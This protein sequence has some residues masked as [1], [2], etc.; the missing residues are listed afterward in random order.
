MKIKYLKSGLILSIFWIHFTLPALEEGIEELTK[1]LEQLQHK[2]TARPTSPD[3]AKDWDLFQFKMKKIRF[4][5]RLYKPTPQLLEIVGREIKKVNKILLALETKKPIK[6][7]PGVSE[8]AY[9]DDTDGSVQPFITYLPKTYEQQKAYPLII[10]LHGYSPYLNIFN[11]SQL[12]EGLT[13]LADEVNALVALPFG[14]SNTDFQGIGEQDVLNVI[15]QVK[16]RYKIDNNRIFL[17]GMSMGGMG[18]WTIISHYPHL[19]AGTIILSGRGDFY[20][21]HKINHKK[22]PYFKKYLIDKE[23]AASHLSNLDRIP[24]WVYHGNSDTLIPIEEARHMNNL[25]K[26]SPTFKYR[27]IPGG[28]HWIYRNVFA[29]P[30][31]KKWLKTAKRKLPES[32][33]YIS[34]HP[35]YNQA[36]W[37]FISEY[38]K[39]NQSAA[40]KVEVKDDKIRIKT[41][42]VKDLVVDRN[43]MP[44]R[45][46]K[47]EIVKDSEFNLKEVLDFKNVKPPYPWGPVKDAFLKPFMFVNAGVNDKYIQQRVLEW[48]QF[49][50]SIPRLKT[51][52]NLSEKDKNN[53]NLF[54]YGEPETSPMIREILKNTPIKITETDYVVGEEKFP[55]KANGLF[56]K[57]PSPWNPAKSVVIQCGVPWGKNASENHRYDLIPGYLIYS[58][59]NNPRDPFGGN[60]TLKGGFF[61]KKGKIS[62]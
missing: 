30:E 42:G 3:L 8:E 57:Y 39:A 4:L 27:E 23:F 5:L 52:K 25:L 53:Y 28:D 17:F 6:P 19:F 35:E 16:N 13:A 43:L 56:L 15:Q 7:I 20:F 29:D 45:I 38:E 12:P 1:S 33:R 49:V 44:E 22:L 18:A 51:E 32:F 9:F 21:W 46:K 60:K 48:Y 2:Q 40:I 55:R 54:L 58:E 31:L 11:W 26:D 47:F 36:H 41:L 62:H 24:I 10:Y 59:K 61:D 37:L 14:R 34:F 50:K